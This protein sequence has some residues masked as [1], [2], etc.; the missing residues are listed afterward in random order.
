MKEIKNQKDHIFD[1]SKSFENISNTGK[2]YGR[3]EMLLDMKILLPYLLKLW[4]KEQETEIRDQIGK[5]E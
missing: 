3:L 5:K 1:L 4:L 2:L